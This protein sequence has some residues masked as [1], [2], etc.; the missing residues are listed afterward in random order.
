MAT[1]PTT[2]THLQ[3]AAAVEDVHVQAFRWMLLAR[4]LDDNDG[5]AATTLAWL[6]DWI[7]DPDAYERANYIKILHGY[8]AR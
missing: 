2:E 1:A 5:A 4:V 7:D 8:A 3:P 6:R